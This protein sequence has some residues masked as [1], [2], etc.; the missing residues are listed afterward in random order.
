MYSLK[1]SPQI[2][3]TGMNVRRKVKSAV[4]DVTNTFQLKTSF[5]YVYMNAMANIKKEN[6]RVDI[7]K[8]VTIPIVINCFHVDKFTLLMRI[9]QKSSNVL[10]KRFVLLQNSSNKTAGDVT[11]RRKIVFF[12]AV[13][14][15]FVLSI[16]PAK[17][18]NP[19]IE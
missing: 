7:T 6:D 18:R 4:K 17:S 3:I 12:K 5:L 9:Q 14:M 16:I 11:K 15:L 2:M 19:R 13:E 8:P 10:F 1:D